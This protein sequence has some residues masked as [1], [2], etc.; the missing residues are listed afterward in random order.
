MLLFGIF[1]NHTGSLAGLF[2]VNQYYRYDNAPALN[3]SDGRI[4]YL[5]KMK[6]TGFNFK[7][8]AG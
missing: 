5:T 1:T 8:R 7:N 6:S 2:D 3:Q 4:R